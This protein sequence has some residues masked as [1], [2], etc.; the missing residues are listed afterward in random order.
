MLFEKMSN[1]LVIFFGIGRG[2][3]I[4]SEFYKQ[5]L[6]LKYDTIHLYIDQK[7]VENKSQIII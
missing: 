2:G 1:N 7:K 5:N 6:G 4:A 3:R